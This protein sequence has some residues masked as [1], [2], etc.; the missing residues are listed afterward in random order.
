M[1]ITVDSIETT[2]YSS[3]ESGVL[4]QNTDDN[5]KVNKPINSNSYFLLHL[6]W[7]AYD[8]CIYRACSYISRYL[9][10]RWT[11]GFQFKNYIG[12][13]TISFPPHDLL[14]REKYKLSFI[15]YLLYFNPQKKKPALSREHWN[16]YKKQIWN[17]KQSNLQKWLPGANSCIYFIFN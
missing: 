6:Y 2:P 1:I 15:F 12:S 4:A 11:V 9:S 7:L 3:Y 14:F 10:S 17:R 16:I 8:F 5:T 13:W